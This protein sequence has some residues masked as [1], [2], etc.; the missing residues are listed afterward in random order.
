VTGKKIEEMEDICIFRGRVSG[1][2]EDGVG[3]SQCAGN[4]KSNPTIQEV[5]LSG[6]IHLSDAGS[7]SCL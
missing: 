5:Q 3:T 2:H 4:A 7:D 1:A 6:R